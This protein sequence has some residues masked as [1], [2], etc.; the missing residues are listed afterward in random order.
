MINL[1][2]FEKLAIF[3]EIITTIKKINSN[4][5]EVIEGVAAKAAKGVIDKIVN[6]VIFMWINYT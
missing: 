3:K 2:L 4:H 6:K 1:F 5:N